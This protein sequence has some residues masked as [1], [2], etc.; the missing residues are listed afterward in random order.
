VFESS[1]RLRDEIIALLDAIRGIV[2]ARYACVFEPARILFESPDPEGNE[3]MTLRRLIDLNGKAIFALPAQMES[4]GAG[5]ESDPFEGWEH[6]EL[7]LAFLNGKVGIALACSDA[8]EAREP[9]LKALQALADRLMRLDERY[10]LDERGRGL[11]L[12]KPRL[13]FVTIAA[14]RG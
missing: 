9:I 11:I 2:N 1:E 6:D 7:L 14:P 3:M 8:E 13:D 5:P 4:G 12:G 10:R